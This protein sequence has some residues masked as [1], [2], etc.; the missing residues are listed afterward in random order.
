[1]RFNVFLGG[2]AAL[3]AGV[4]A[5]YYLADSP[6]TTTLGPLLAARQANSTTTMSVSRTT[7]TPD[8]WQCITENITQYFDVPKPSG[9]LHDAIASYNGEVNKACLA[10]AV[11]YE[12]RACTISNPTLW[13]GITAPAPLDVI[14]SYSA[15]V[16]EAVTFWTAKSSTMS[17]LSTSCAVA[18][19]RPV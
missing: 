18:W 15:Y 13:C 5:R 6:P 7:L 16:S 4:S 3:M 2:L 8:P 17:I 9:D 14:S 19:G 11:G 12:K 1:V 10:T